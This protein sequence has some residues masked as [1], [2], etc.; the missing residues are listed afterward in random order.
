MA[1]SKTITSTSRT[2]NIEA[3]VWAK[4][5]KFFKTSW[6]KTTQPS[7]KIN[8]QNSTSTTKSSTNGVRYR[9]QAI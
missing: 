8:T 2:L 1:S 4:S 5:S 6:T 7:K 3:K 9:S